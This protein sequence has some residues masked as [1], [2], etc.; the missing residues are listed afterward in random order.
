LD[1]IA[2][3]FSAGIA[4]LCGVAAGLAPALGEN[5]RQV[6]HA[7][8]ESS[9]SASSGHGSVKLRRA[10]LA[11]EVA[12]TVVLLVGAGLLLRSYQKL[13]AVDIGV[14]THKVLTMSI[15]LPDGAYGNQ[16]AYSAKK[17]AF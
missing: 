8:Q 6:L 12:L 1:G 15:N 17:V 9:R 7:L 14:P 5:E 3:L 4:I 10:L 13:R 2:I 11:A 16:Q